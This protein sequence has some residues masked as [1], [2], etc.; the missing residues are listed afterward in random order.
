MP[1]RLFRKL[2]KQLADAYEESGPDGFCE[3]VDDL[4]PDEDVRILYD[5]HPNMQV[6]FPIL[7]FEKQELAEDIE[8]E[9]IA[10]W[11]PKMSRT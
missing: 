8:A 4:M 1:K 6:F 7:L 11:A 10:R 2:V 3:I 5:F 9:L